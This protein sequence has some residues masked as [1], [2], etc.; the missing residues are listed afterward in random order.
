MTT[1]KTSLKTILNVFFIFLSFSTFAQIGYEKGHF[2]NNN[3]EKIECFIKNI[4]WKNNPTKIS[5][6]ISETSEPISI[7]I[8]S[9][10]SF[11]IEDG[12][13]Y[14]R[15]NVEINV[16]ERKL[17]DKKDF[18]LTKKTVFLKTLVKGKSDLY[19]YRDSRI[20]NFFYKVPNKGI[21]LL[22][23]KKYINDNSQ[24]AYNSM[25]KRQL[26]EQ[27]KCE[28]ISF[29]EVNS[30][31]YEENDLIN[32]FKTYNSCSNFLDYVYEKKKNKSV[33]HLSVRP[34]INYAT[35][36]IEN[37]KDNSGSLTRAIEFDRNVS[38]RLGA[39]FE[40][41]L[42]FNR[43]KWSFIV[44]PTYHYF[45]TN[46][47]INVTPSSPLER[48]EDVTIDYTSLEVPF[49]FRHYMFLNESSKLFF[50]VTAILDIPFNRSIKYEGDL[51]SNIELEITSGTNIALGVG[52]VY[53]R[54]SIQ[55]RFYS[56]RDLLTKYVRTEG[57]YKNISL[58]L[59]Y[60]LF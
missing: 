7:G 28:S 51:N 10:K 44:E 56:S 55:A 27:L 3:N 33:F 25:F 13:Q 46:K 2:I 41:V 18:E 39:E 19:V 17:S 47:T 40:Y 21:F 4:E 23:Y 6:K 32:F 38:F 29:N 36:E 34:G 53:D 1:L 22:R 42:P 8:E 31:E 35:A 52:Y 49:G 24:I 15:A 11:G 45:K 14:V 43:N 30:L 48:Y 59:G 12:S 37:D 50:D 26:F 57:R 5:Y 9:V 58:I 54:Y 16:V 20:I 60:K